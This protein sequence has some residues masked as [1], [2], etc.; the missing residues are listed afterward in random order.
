MSPP[1]IPYNSDLLPK[2]FRYPTSYL[3]CVEADDLQEKSNWWFP[4]EEFGH[5]KSEWG[6][7]LHWKERGWRYLADIDPIPFARNGDL[8]AFFDGADHSGDPKIVVVDLGNRENSYKL[9]NF[10]AWLQ[11]ARGDSGLK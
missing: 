3:E 9:E 2:G 11:Q 8:A 10:D 1:G 7:R 5:A 4:S 6:V